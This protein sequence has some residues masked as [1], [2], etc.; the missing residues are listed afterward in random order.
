MSR[1]GIAVEETCGNTSGPIQVRFD[2][3]VWILKF[4]RDEV[5]EVPTSVGEQARIEGYSN[6]ANT[7]VSFERLYKIG[8]VSCRDID[9][10][11]FYCK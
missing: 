6:T 11:E 4:L 1:S 9:Y 10:K 7:V 8:G 2:Q 3:P 5:Q